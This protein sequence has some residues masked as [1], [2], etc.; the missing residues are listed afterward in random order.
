LA[1]RNEIA[2]EAIVTRSAAKWRDVS[3]QVDTTAATMS[4]R[5]A[6]GSENVSKWVEMYNLLQGSLISAGNK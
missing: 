5:Q 4:K 3:D 6:E 2:A 1:L